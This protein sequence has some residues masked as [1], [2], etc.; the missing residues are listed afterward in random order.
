MDGVQAAV[1]D[2]APQV[3]QRGVGQ[4][5]RAEAAAARRFECCECC[6]GRS[7][8]PAPRWPG[9]AVPGGQPLGGGF[10]PFD[11]ARV[12][13]AQIDHQLTAAQV[14]GRGMVHG[15]DAGQLGKFFGIAAGGAV[16]AAVNDNSL[17][18]GPPL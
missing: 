10:Q 17:H 5:G 9:S 7:R 12:Q 13:P 2:A 1:V 6:P 4:Q 15:G 3:E 18:G 16:F 14:P 8:R 11:A